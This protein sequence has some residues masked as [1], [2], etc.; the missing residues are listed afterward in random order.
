MTLEEQEEMLKSASPEER[1]R[2]RRI[3]D[4][5]DSPGAVIAGYNEVEPDLTPIRSID[6]LDD[7][8]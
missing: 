1:A 5:Q 8:K 2:I 4:R 3:E 6:D 7:S